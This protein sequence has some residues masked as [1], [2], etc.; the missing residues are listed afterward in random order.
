MWSTEHSLSY[1]F[2]AIRFE[3]VGFE[4]NFS[5]NDYN[6]G[7]KLLAQMKILLAT[8]SGKS[9][10]DELHWITEQLLT[11]ECFISV[12]NFREIAS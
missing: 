1:P 12:W 2:V 3:E 10:E 11:F 4:S 8:M 7:W 6:K 5:F 9:Q